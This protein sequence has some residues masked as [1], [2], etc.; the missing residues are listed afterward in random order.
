M[1]EEVRKKL[2]TTQRRMMRTIMQTKR[3]TGEGHAAAHAASVDDTADVELRDPDSEPVDHTT[4]H[5]NQDLNE[6]KR[7]EP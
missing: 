5:D 1:T 7:K 2:Q 6:Q 3:K 4:E